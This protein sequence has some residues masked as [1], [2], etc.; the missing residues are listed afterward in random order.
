[1]EIFQDII[2][3]K[4]IRLISAVSLEKGFNWIFYHLPSCPIR[5]E[6]GQH[7]RVA[8]H[9]RV[10]EKLDRKQYKPEGISANVVHTAA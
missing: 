7:N 5:V 2:L 1:L 10:G 8:V 3:I 4:L 6:D 9:G